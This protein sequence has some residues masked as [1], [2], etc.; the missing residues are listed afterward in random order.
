MHPVTPGAQ[1]ARTCPTSS[2]RPALLPTKA[3]QGLPLNS[4]PSPQTFQFP[5]TVFRMRFAPL[6]NFLLRPN[7]N[8]PTNEKWKTWVISKVETDLSRLR[9]PSLSCGRVVDQLPMFVPQNCPSQEELSKL[10]LNE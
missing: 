9:G 10:L 1:L 8:S 6:K 4:V 3:I 5:T 2:G 7:G